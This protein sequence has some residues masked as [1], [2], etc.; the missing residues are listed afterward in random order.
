MT[1]C[2]NSDFVRAYQALDGAL[3]AEFGGIEGYLV[4]ASAVHRYEKD[5][6]PDF[7]RDIAMLREMRAVSL[8]LMETKRVSAAI[9]SEDGIDYLRD[10]QKRLSEGRDPLGSLKTPPIENNPDAR[11][12]LP[13]EAEAREISRK[14]ISQKKRIA[15]ASLA[16]ALVTVA[17]TALLWHKREDTV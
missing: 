3:S 6:H 12:Y 13:I 11:K 10:F 5:G 1:E 17:I 9:A 14:V 2:I 16:A 8:S 4:T 7:E 15:V